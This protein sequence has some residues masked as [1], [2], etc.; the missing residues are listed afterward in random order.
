[1]FSLMGLEVFL[2]VSK[3]VNWGCFRTCPHALDFY[4]VV[5]ESQETVIESRWFLKALA[6]QMV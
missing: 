4:T 2:A 3:E 5:V 1:M 6:Q